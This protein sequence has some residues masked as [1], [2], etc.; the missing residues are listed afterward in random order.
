M[1]MSPTRS[2]SLFEAYNVR[3]TGQNK[4]EAKNFFH[5][6]YV[7]R[8]YNLKYILVNRPASGESYFPY[9]ALLISRLKKAYAKGFIAEF[10]TNIGILYAKSLLH[11][12][13]C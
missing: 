10:R 2:L 7:L 4:F 11:G 13:E 3:V 8:I 12:V 6:R 1:V 9:R 5:L